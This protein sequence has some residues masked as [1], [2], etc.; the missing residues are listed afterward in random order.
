MDRASH[1]SL[2]NHLVIRQKAKF[3]RNNSLQ[4]PADKSKCFEIKETMKTRRQ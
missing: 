4:R 1:C 3:F 2:G